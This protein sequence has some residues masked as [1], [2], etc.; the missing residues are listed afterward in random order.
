M[1]PYFTGG[2]FNTKSQGQVTIG[3]MITQIATPSKETQDILN[4]IKVATQNKDEKLKSQLKAK[5]PYYTPAVIIKQRKYEFIECFT[6]FMPV[7]FD[8]LPGDDAIGL[9][10]QLMTH[11]FFMCAWL[12]AS[13]KGVRGLVHVPICKT[14]DEYKLRFKALSEELSIY[15]G[16]DMAPKCPILPLYYS[17]DPDILTNLDF[18]TFTKIYQEPPPV[19][20]ENINTYAVNGADK[21]VVTIMKK[22]IDTIT[23]EGHYTLRAASYALGGYVA[24]GYITEPDAITL[25][26]SMIENNSYLCKKQSIYKRTAKEMIIKGQ[27]QKLEL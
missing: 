13:C 14:V 3:E 9:K 12:S 10:R 23:T 17:H 20:K 7:D 19:R 25:M 26:D 27:G 18:T 15:N 11:S 2:V 8:K 6:G 24:A 22:K 1:I 21:A 4:Q 5:L 16:F